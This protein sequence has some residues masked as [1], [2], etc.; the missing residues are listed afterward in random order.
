M[1]SWMVPGLALVLGLFGVLLVIDAV[2]V[3]V[4]KC[5]LPPAGPLMGAF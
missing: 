3:F 5:T 1:N 4:W 2:C